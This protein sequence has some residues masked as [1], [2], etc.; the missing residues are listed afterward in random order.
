MK[1]VVD[2]NLLLSGTLW[3]GS[4]ARLLNAVLSA[5]GTLCLS[6]E[7]I[8]EFGEVLGRKEFAARLASQGTTVSDVMQRYQRLGRR[9]LPAQLS[10]VPSLRDPKDLKILAAAVGAKADA[11]VTGDNDLLVLKEFAGIPIIDAAE[12]LKR[13]GLS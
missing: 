9:I 3:R 7:I 11:I 1:L 12:A 13:L 2:T 8:L 10:D 5:P 4:P 6:A